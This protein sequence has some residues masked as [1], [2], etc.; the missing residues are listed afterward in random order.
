ME[1]YN[2]IIYLLIYYY[3]YY[4]YLLSHLFFFLQGDLDWSIYN[5]VDHRSAYHFDGIIQ[6]QIFD[7]QH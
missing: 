3:Y 1:I 5:T 4:Y 2:N 6:N 7:S